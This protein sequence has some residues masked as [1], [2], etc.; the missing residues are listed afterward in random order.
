VRSTAVHS[1]ISIQ[2][3]RLNFLAA[4]YGCATRFLTQP[5]D[6]WGYAAEDMEASRRVSRSRD[7]SV[8]IVTRMRAGRSRIRIQASVDFLFF[9]TSRRALEPMTPPTQAAPEAHP[10]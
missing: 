1:D 6:V 8:D 9:E 3:W 2:G 4:L 7:S 10:P 5:K